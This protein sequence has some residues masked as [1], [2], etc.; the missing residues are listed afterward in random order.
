MQN[1]RFQKVNLLIGSQHSIVSAYL[2]LNYYFER[3]KG[4]QI[5]SEIENAL[6]GIICAFSDPIIKHHAS[7]FDVGD[8][9]T[10]KCEQLSRFLPL[11]G[12]RSTTQHLRQL[13]ENK[14][15]IEESIFA[16]NEKIDSYPLFTLLKLNFS[17]LTGADYLA[18]LSYQ[19][20]VDLPEA[21]DVKKLVSL[22]A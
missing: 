17:L 3:L 13:I 22:T 19:N 8:L 2:F 10:V 16:N 20:Q 9:D 15:I 4:L 14:R 6:S 1:K 5:G 7:T 11:I 18:T 21:D 12:M